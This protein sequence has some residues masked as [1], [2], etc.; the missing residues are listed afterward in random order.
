VWLFT[1]F[2]GVC[3]QFY[4]AFDGNVF[5]P[6]SSI[7]WFSTNLETSIAQLALTKLKAKRQKKNTKWHYFFTKTKYVWT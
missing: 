4:E 2:F 1:H 6:R 3:L 5:H 7:G